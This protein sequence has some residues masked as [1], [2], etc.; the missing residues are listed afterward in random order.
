MTRPEGSTWTSPS[1]PRAGVCPLRPPGFTRSRRSW[2]TTASGSARP[3]TTFIV[4]VGKDA[5]TLR[6]LD[7]VLV[8]PLA[9]KVPIGQTGVPGPV[10][11]ASA[12]ALEADAASFTSGTSR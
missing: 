4:Y 1:T 10:P 9:A 7:T 11:A 6:R 8:V 3:L 2:K 5:S 12:S